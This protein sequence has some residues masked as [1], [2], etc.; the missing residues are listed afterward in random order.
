MKRHYI[1]KIHLLS[2]HLLSQIIVLTIFVLAPFCSLFSQNIS[3]K[4]YTWGKVKTE[5]NGDALNVNVHFLKNAYSHPEFDVLNS[6]NE[7]NTDNKKSYFRVALPAGYSVQ[8]SKAKIGSQIQ[9]N[10]GINQNGLQVDEIEWFRGIQCARLSID[11]STLSSDVDSIDFNLPLIRNTSNSVIS[12][13]Y[14]DKYFSRVKDILFT[15]YSSSAESYTLLQWN[16]T[17]GGWIQYNQPY[18]RLSIPEDGIY[19]LQYQDIASIYSQASAIEPTTLKL[20]NKGKEI[21][22]Y[23]QGEED[24]EFDEGDYIEFPALK[25]YGEKDY[26][27]I[28][29]SNEE[30]P[31]YMNRYTDTSY[32]WLTWGG[33]AGKRLASNDGI[34]SSDTLLWYTEKIHVEKDAWLLPIGSDDIQN[35]Y[36]YW[37][38][39]DMWC[40][41]FLGAGGKISF[42]VNTSD[43][44]A[45][46]PGKVFVRFANYGASSTAPQKV[47]ITFNSSAVLDSMYLNRFGHGLLSANVDPALI[48]SGNNALYLWSQSLSSGW[49]TVVYDWGELEYPRTLKVIND[50]LVATFIEP[51][52]IGVHTLVVQGFTS[53]SIIIYKISQTPK[54]ISHYELSTGAAPYS[55]SFPDTVNL[56]DKYIFCTEETIKKPRICEIKQFVNLRNS[57]HKADYILLTA[58]T[59]LT[60]A[61]NYCR[62]IEQS[63]GLTTALINIRDVFDEFGYG[64]PTSESI[65]EFLRA[66][67]RWQLPMPSYLFIVGDGTYDFK[68]NLAGTDTSKWVPNFVP[69]YGYPVSDALYTVLD[70]ASPLPQLYVGRLPVE[71]AD[72][73][74]HYFEHY[75]QY[76]LQPND[77]W[78]KTFL[79]FS[80]GSSSNPSEITIMKNVNQSVID[81]IIKPVPLGGKARHFYKT[82]NPPSD[83]GPFSVDEIQHAIDEGGIVI[84]YIGHSGTQTW[85][86]GITNINQLKNSVNRFPLICDFGCST[87]K[88]AESNIRCFGELFVTTD[89]VPAIGYIGNSSL[90]FLTFAQRAPLL[91][92]LT[93]IKDTVHCIGQTHLITKLR[94]VGTAS[95]SMLNQILLY[96]NTLLGDPSVQIAL[97][98]APNFRI[99]ESNISSTPNIPTDNEQLLNLTIPYINSG[100]VVPDTVKIKI[101]HL[102]QGANYDTLIYRQCPLFFDTL[103]VSYPIFG[104]P[105]EHRFSIHLNPNLEIPEITEKDNSASKS[106][107]VLSNAFQLLKPMSQFEMF[108]N[109]IELVNPTQ[110]IEEGEKVEF[111]ID[112]LEGF[113]MARQ[114]EAQ[115]GKVTTK[116]S[117]LSLIEGQR[118]FWRAKLQGSSLWSNGSFR[119]GFDSI[120][121]WHPVSDEW[122][123]LTSMDSVK[124]FPNAGVQFDSIYTNVNIIAASYYEG[125][126]GNVKFD[127]KEALPNTFWWGHSVIVIDTITAQ[128]ITVQQFEIS[129]ATGSE[130]TRLA[131][132]LENLPDGTM[133]IQVATTD[134]AQ[135]LTTRIKN[136]VKKFGSRY[137]DS[138]QYRD[139]WIMIGKKG[140]PVGS[141]REVWHKGIPNV[142][143]PSTLDT[144]FL[145]RVFQGSIQTHIIG[146]ASKWNEMA[147]RKV[148]P[149]GTSIVTTILGI[150]KNGE[151][152]TLISSSPDTI[153]S[154]S[155]IPANI[156]PNIKLAIILNGDSIGASPVV[157][158]LSV[159]LIPPAELAIGPRTVS[160]VGDSLLE[161]STLTIQSDI[162]NVGYAPADSFYVTGKIISSHGIRALDT[163]FVQSLS[164]DSSINIHYSLSTQGLRGANSF[165]IEVDPNNNI[166]ELYRSNNTYAQTFY[167][168]TDTIPPMFDIT[169]NGR[170][171]LNGDYVLANP[172]I[173]ISITDNS[174]MLIT[175][176]SN[177]LLM[178]DNRR[179]QLAAATQDS[180]F[181]S[182]TISE[183][184]RITYRPSLPKG[185]HALEIRVKD[186]TGNWSDS[187]ATKIVFQVETESRLLQVYNYPNPFGRTTYFTFIITGRTMPEEVLIKIYTV[188]G[189][190]IKTI[191]CNQ[192]ELQA[193]F[194]RVYWDGRD[195]EGDEIANGIYLY[196]ILMKCENETVEATQKLAI[197]R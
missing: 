159:S 71:S 43:V 99:N 166:S 183:P 103:D 126:Y 195:A 174:P 23:V 12:P 25:N 137:I 44:F 175:D 77:E 144:T 96:T 41:S 109:E 89:D 58:Q 196:K 191:R 154:L 160:V 73:F 106:V 59:F 194:N 26:R 18:V 116:I 135:G 98:S 20:F 162:Y 57:A 4:S 56:N 52:Q 8:S 32:Y 24:G 85:D 88:F 3:E 29:S 157:K 167:V 125:S 155:K 22:V 101:S 107:V 42:P 151:V 11:I 9:A 131:T 189:R 82:I 133:I 28:P 181:T 45:G 37:Q 81:T 90:G 136:A 127:G 115:I 93:L 95:Q 35:Q 76:N 152:D 117:G 188:A 69:P 19:R 48:K 72:E 75:Q 114:H 7:N 16:D 121:K 187:I 176:P 168:G 61:E 6:N 78:N 74:Q 179:V 178:L 139:S 83:M 34:T 17:T 148:M 66:T 1:E 111:E 2:N 46:K 102:F 27:Q 140:M 119:T 185:E 79:M 91:F 161:G 68:Y 134:G 197:V 97:P 146:Q 38:L 186:V 84:N 100:L 128:P 150:Q 62:Y 170:R 86:N 10:V 70:D 163:V 118:Y 108:T 21:P 31:E 67:T 143:D 172:R 87:A 123:T 110:K 15:N 184:A 149:Q 39:N 192:S 156:Y 49:N 165:I 124:Y 40:W 104:L 80:G 36:P 55:V 171:I 122:Q 120:V 129:D 147:M 141:A 177:V 65:S 92:Y 164:N 145:K 47:W 13:K 113:G 105:G 53:S 30:Y 132:F 138:I 14:W 169:F 112:T 182:Q 63:T 193:G 54:K 130:A 158:D 94:Y 153:I 64:Y 60:I 180:L 190:L 33:E 51:E 5:Q 142:I 173:D 50:R